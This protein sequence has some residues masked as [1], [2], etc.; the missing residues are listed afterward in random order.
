MMTLGGF[1]QSPISSSRGETS[2]VKSVMTKDFYWIIQFL[3][4]SQTMVDTFLQI[5]MDGR[6][7]QLECMLN[8]VLKCDKFSQQFINME[9]HQR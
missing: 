6:F 9:K 7:L 8:L 4:K 1:L 3:L 2:E 5:V